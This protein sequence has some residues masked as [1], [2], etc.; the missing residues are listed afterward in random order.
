M[1]VRPAPPRVAIIILNWNGWSDTLECLESVF[2]LRYP[3]ITVIVCD[4]ASTD[5]SLDRI[6]AWAAG[7]L[8]ASVSSPAFAG[9]NKTPISKPIPTETINPEGSTAP[10]TADVPLFLIPTGAN[11]GFAGGNNAG[12]RFGLKI[13][14]I[15]YF[16]L[17]NN[18]TVVDEQALTA[19]VNL[20]KADPGIGLCGSVLRDYRQPDAVLTLGGRKYSPWSGRTQPI[21][22]M[23]DKSAEGTLIALDYVEAASMLARRSFLESVGLMAEDYFLYFEELDWALRSRGRFRLGFSSGS[24]V[25]HKEGS[26]I[27]SHKNRNQRSTLS[28]F[29]S[30]RNRVVFTWRYYPFHLPTILLSVVATAVHR[31]LSGR[32]KNAA[33]IMRGML[34]ALKP[35]GTA[36]A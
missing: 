30:A 17:L 29:F 25:Y 11:L 20:M 34:S 4:N 28:D 23:S 27:G 36:A 15:D 35:H 7:S 5:G 8:V 14:D 9:L 12:L 16:W 21:R 26:S 18:D 19:L 32:A 13:P 22:S 31:L 6:R 24:I 3:S 2:R 1:A 33:A 10:F